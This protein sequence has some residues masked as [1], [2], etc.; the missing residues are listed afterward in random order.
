MEI[1]LVYVYMYNTNTLADFTVENFYKNS[2]SMVGSSKKYALENPSLNAID[3]D[4][5]LN[6]I[7]IENY[8]KEMEL[9]AKD[10]VEKYVANKIKIFKEHLIVKKKFNIIIDELKILIDDY[11][12]SKVPADKCVIDNHDSNE[13]GILYK[14]Y[15][16]MNIGQ[17]SRITIDCRCSPDGSHEFKLV[18]YLIEDTGGLLMIYDYEKKTQTFKT[19]EGFSVALELIGDKIVN[20]INNT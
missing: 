5:T 17:V 20:L 13:E 15:Y 14:T 6:W 2:C 19:I 18:D 11:I 16:F 7:I 12:L 10:Y 3:V 1:T 4:E 9:F 8:F